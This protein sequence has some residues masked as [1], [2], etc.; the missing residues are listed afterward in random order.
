[1]WTRKDIL[2][3]VLAATATFGLALVTLLPRV[4]SATQEEKTTTVLSPVLHVGEC[5]VQAQAESNTLPQNAAVNGA[6]RPAAL[7]GQIFVTAGPVPS[8]KLIAKNPADKEAMV[9]INARLRAT[10]GSSFSRTMPYPETKWSETYNLVLKAGE[11]REIE[12]DTKTSLAPLTYSQFELQSGEDAS[13]RITALS[14][15]VMLKAAVPTAGV[16]QPPSQ[17]ALAAK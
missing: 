9:V 17:A 6:V 1:M 15:N 12:V 8:I 5:D 13:T 14:I 3:V 7:P 11:T 16:I 2:T 10:A 4:A